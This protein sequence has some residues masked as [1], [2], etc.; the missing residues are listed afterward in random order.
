MFTESSFGTNVAGKH[1]KLR[2]QTEISELKTTSWK[3]LLHS[4]TGI[5]LSRLFVMGQSHLNTNTSE[6]IEMYRDWVPFIQFS[7]YFRLRHWFSYLEGNPL[8]ITTVVLYLIFNHKDI[9]W[10]AS[11][12]WVF[13]TFLYLIQGTTLKPWRRTQSDSFNKWKKVEE[14]SEILFLPSFFKKLKQH[15][16]IFT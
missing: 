6:F 5:T 11:V 8:S 4:K 14:R 1:D 13:S 7:E 12:T 15:V 16:S 9:W 2:V 3:R 10:V